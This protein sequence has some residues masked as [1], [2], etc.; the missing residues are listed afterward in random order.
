VSDF[1]AVTVFEIPVLVPPEELTAAA[2][3]DFDER[4]APHL[5]CGAPGLVVDLTAVATLTSA[6]LGRLVLLGRSLD[7][8]GTAVVLAGGR[9]SIVK[10]IRTVG[11]DTVMPHFASVE[12]A[13]AFIRER[14]PPEG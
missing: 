5:D 4:A 14:H 2:E 10:L 1:A 3:S 9:R 11:L 13:S 6:G 7:E 12:E 8:R